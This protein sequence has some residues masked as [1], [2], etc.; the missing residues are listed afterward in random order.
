MRKQQKIR[1]LKR[2]VVLLAVLLLLFVISIHAGYTKMGTADVFRTLLGKGNAEEALILFDF[3]LVR[4]VLAMLVGAGLSVS[5]TIFQTISKNALASPDLLGVSAG[6]GIAVLLYTF[7]VPEE[8]AVGVF[9]LPFVS[10]AGALLTAMLIYSLAHQKDR[11]ISP[12]RLVLIG[13]SVTSGINAAEIIFTVRLSPEKFQIVHTWMIGSVYGNTWSHVLALLP[14]LVVIIPFLIYRSRDLNLMRL[15]DGVA[16][17]L[18]SP[19][20]K[21]RFLYLMLAV[22][23]AAACVSVGGAI[24]FVGLICPHLARKLVGPNHQYCIPVS[25]VTGAVLLL[26][27]DLVARTIIAPNEML[28]G[29]VVSLIGAPYFLYILL[30]SKS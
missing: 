25:A 9:A 6:A 13:I 30:T 5:G 4:I 18:G 24:G 14:W 7:F 1:F 27:A 10:L 17:G 11:A 21:S 3:R 29:I 16:I 20:K 15:S 23:L 8:M 12:V 26:G 19:L 28:L 22:A 2:L